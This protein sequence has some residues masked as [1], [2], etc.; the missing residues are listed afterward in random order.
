MHIVL[1]RVCCD[2]L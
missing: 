1:C 2:S